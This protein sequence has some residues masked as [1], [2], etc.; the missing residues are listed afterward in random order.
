MNVRL[1]IRRKYKIIIWMMWLEN[2]RIL[3]TKRMIKIIIENWWNSIMI[4]DLS[5]QSIIDNTIIRRNIMICILLMWSQ[6]KRKRVELITLGRVGLNGLIVI[7][8]NRGNQIRII[9]I[10][11]ERR[12]KG[13]LDQCIHYIRL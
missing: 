7:M 3:N 10:C 4:G 5:I 6:D 9:V 11:L 13:R 1:V 8:I 2:R 12:V